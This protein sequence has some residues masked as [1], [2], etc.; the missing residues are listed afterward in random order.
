MLGGDQA[1]APPCAGAQT[2]HGKDP[3]HIGEGQVR[4]QHVRPQ[5]PHRP[6]HRTHGAQ[7]AVLRAHRAGDHGGS[8]RPEG[9]GERPFGAQ[10]HHAGTG[11]ARA[12]RVQGV[13]CGPAEV[14]DRHV[15]E[16]QNHVCSRSSAV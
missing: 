13:A 8:L 5:V 4:V 1:D 15:P 11:N 12:R 9:H 10:H 2:D 7:R 6:P 16:A 14:A 3:H